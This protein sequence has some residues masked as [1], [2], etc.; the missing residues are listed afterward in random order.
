MSTEKK[1]NSLESSRIYSGGRDKKGE[2]RERKEAK[3]GRIKEQT[4]TE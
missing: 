1:K 2:G 4:R 3:E